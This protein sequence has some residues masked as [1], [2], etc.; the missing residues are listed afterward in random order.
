MLSAVVA[1]TVMFVRIG[2][3][4]LALAVP[5]MFM[6]APLFVGAPLLNGA[7]L[8]DAVSLADE[9]ILP[10]GA[11][12]SPRPLGS[13]RPPRPPLPRLPEFVPL[14]AFAV[15]F[16]A[17]LRTDRPAARSSNSSLNGVEP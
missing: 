14:R 16:G 10:D 15:I 17:T 4:S 2:M 3:A 1:F 13:P 6:G 12:R 5:L 8:V 9:A 7:P 11:P